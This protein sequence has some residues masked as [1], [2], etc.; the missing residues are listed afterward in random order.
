MELVLPEELLQAVVESLAFDTPFVERQLR[1]LRWKYSIVELL[2]LSLANRQ[3]RRISMPFLFAFIRIK[4][5]STDVE[6]LIDQC[7]SN[8]AFAASIR[9]LYLNEELPQAS[10]SEAEVKKVDCLLQHLTHLSQINLGWISLDRL[11]LAVINRH[12]VPTV[13]LPSRRIHSMLLHKA[14]ELGSS[15]L[16]K[17]VLT[18]ENDATIDQ[19]ESDHLQDFLAHGMQLTHVDATSLHS[20]FLAQK[21]HGLCHLT[22]TLDNAP[23]SPTV[24]SWLPEFMCSHELLKTIRF[25][26]GFRWNWHINTI[27][28]V[29]LLIE[30]ISK[31]GLADSRIIRGF[32]I[33]RAN[34]VAVNRSK[35]RAPAPSSE[36][37]VSGLDLDIRTQSPGRILYVAHGLF[38]QISALSLEVSVTLDELVTALTCFS[39]LRVVNLVHPS[40]L[41]GFG[42]QTPDAADV[43]NAIIQYTSLMAQRI[44]NLEAFHIDDLTT[45]RAYFYGWL[46][47]QQ[48]LHERRT[49]G[50]LWQ[51]IRESPLEPLPPDSR[52][53]YSYISFD[54][55]F[56]L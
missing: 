19:A 32:D 37:Y 50:P 1:M 56:L 27:P 16:S 42:N 31:E 54:N 52:T 25:V 44:P 21:F 6:K 46:N 17:L 8:Q 30:A 43:Q 10:L 28:F 5:D 18:C 4:A 55:V 20:S 13:F 22:L 3:L 26:A 9:T 29:Q 39:S 48:T 33:T 45:N 40:N 36:W 49:V 15:E 14:H 23:T 11:L 34:P 53:K 51:L 35:L 2:P 47:V 24:M 41:L 38:P 12:P 7:V